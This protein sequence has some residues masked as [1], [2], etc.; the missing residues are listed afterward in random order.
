LTASVQ[1]PERL[2]ALID[3]TVRWI[4][5]Q[6][7]ASGGWLHPKLNRPDAVANEVEL[8]LSHV[9][10]GLV[11]GVS[12]P[13]SGDAPRAEPPT[14]ADARGIIGALADLQEAGR[15]LASAPARGAGEPDCEAA[16]GPAVNDCCPRCGGPV[17]VLGFES[18][19]CGREQIE[20]LGALSW[21]VP[22]GLRA[23]WRA[24]LY[25]VKAHGVG[26]DAG[27]GVFRDSEQTPVW[28]S[29]TVE[30]AQDIA[31]AM[32]FADVAAVRA[33]L[34]SAPRVPK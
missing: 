5:L 29:T 26:R 17:R 19:D 28:M 7:G 1:G 8:R 22:D 11:R 13:D 10:A 4:R 21:G 3:D 33:A 12:L 16:H 23:S 20:Q 32:R 27:Y 34:G 15:R 14:F 31:E 18:C 9:K 30:I 6:R 24:H 25:V 2:A